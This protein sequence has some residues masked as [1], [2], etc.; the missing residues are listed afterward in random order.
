[1]RDLRNLP[2]AVLARLGTDPVPGVDVVTTYRGRE[3]R[4]EER[5]HHIELRAT[6][7][8]SPI[9]EG[10]ASTTG[11]WYDVFGGPPWGWREQIAPGAFEAALSRG[12]DTRM[13]INHGDL[14]IART[15]SGTLHMEEDKLGLRVHTP[16]GV[17]M[18]SPA[19]VTLVTAM[20]RGDVDEMSF[21]FTIDVDADGQRMESWNEDFTERTIRGVRLFDVSVVTYPANPATVAQLRTDDEPAARSGM[22]LSLAQAYAAAARL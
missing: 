15:R 2:P 20:E 14:P 16:S 3:W 5:R 9:I 19:V 6:E 18:R 12:D 17:D 7:D 4:I 22:P 21:A 8:G 10:Y 1:M 13:L 11:Q